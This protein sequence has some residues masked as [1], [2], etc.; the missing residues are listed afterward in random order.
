VKDVF[1][2]L[3]Q[4]LEQYAAGN[5]QQLEQ[6]A[7]GAFLKKDLCLISTTHHSKHFVFL[8]STSYM[9]LEQ[10]FQVYSRKANEFSSWGKP[11]K[12]GY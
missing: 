2:K 6:K 11:R 12:E 4:Q 5:C 8:R 7:T 3:C 1:W 9:F 10:L